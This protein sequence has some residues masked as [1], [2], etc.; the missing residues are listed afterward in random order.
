MLPRLNRL[1]KKKD[2]EETYQQGKAVGG[3]FLLIKT[4]PNQEK[5]TRI[6]IVVSKKVAKKATERNKLK[7]RIREI[8]R[9]KNTKDKL[10]GDIVIIAKKPS[11]KASYRELEADWENVL[12]KLF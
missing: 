7:R 8:V 4:K 6:G 2:F 11:A 12:S 5:Q 1:T 9:K 3:N 10:G